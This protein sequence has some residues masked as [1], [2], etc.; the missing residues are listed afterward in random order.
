LG[1]GEYSYHKNIQGCRLL[2]DRTGNVRRFG[3]TQRALSNANYPSGLITYSI[4]HAID[5]LLYENQGLFRKM[6][7]LCYDVEDLASQ[8]IDS[9]NY[10]ACITGHESLGKEFLTHSHRLDDSDRHTLTIALR[11]SSADERTGS[12]DVWYPFSDD[13]SLL[14]YYYMN[15]EFLDKYVEQAPRYVYPLNTPVNIMTF[16]PSYCAH[17]A[18]WTDDVYMFF[19]YEHVNWKPGAYDYLKT[20]SNKH[21]FTDLPLSKRLTFWNVA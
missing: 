4:E 18:T 7:K 3:N 19:V 16:N 12:I 8:F 1:G 9:C 21:E 6:K 17:T 2:K 11:L 14:P 20:V 10:A 13:D 15:N 5:P